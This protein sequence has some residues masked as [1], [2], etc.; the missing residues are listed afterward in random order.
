MEFDSTMM[1]PLNEDEAP[2][3]P[4]AMA[5]AFAAERQVAAEANTKPIANEEDHKE[6]ISAETKLA[7]EESIRRAIIE[8]GGV[9]ALQIKL[10]EA[11]IPGTEALRGKTVVMV[12][13]EIQAVMQSIEPISVAT[14]GNLELVLQLDKT[15]NVDRL[16][17]RILEKNPD[18][19]IM[20]YNLSFDLTGVEIVNELRARGYTGKIIGSSAIDSNEE[21]FAKIG[22]H[23]AFD[24]QMKRGPEEEMRVLALELEK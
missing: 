7:I 12:D 23:A 4:V 14:N 22:V 5:L 3:D 13:N 6:P 21:I 24:K 18:L 20:D 16:V 1:E 8:A 10:P 17:V 11:Y 19:V 15:D 2:F 9:P